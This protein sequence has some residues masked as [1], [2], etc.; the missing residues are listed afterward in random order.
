MQECRERTFLTITTS[1]QIEEEKSKGKGKGKDK[2]KA[3]A[4]PTPK[5]KEKVEKETRTEKT[6][7]K[8]GKESPSGAPGTGIKEEEKAFPHSE[9]GLKIHGR[10]PQASHGQGQLSQQRPPRH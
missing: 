6:K 1:Q 9:N 4:Q 8:T 7:A 2:G 3:K 5:A 10:L